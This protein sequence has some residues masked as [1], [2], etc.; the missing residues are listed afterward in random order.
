MRTTPSGKRVVEGGVEQRAR[1]RPGA[2][3]TLSPAATR[4]LRASGAFGQ[5]ARRLRVARRLQRRR[6]AHDRVAEVDR[7]VGD[8][9]ERRRRRPAPACGATRRPRSDS[10]AATSAGSASSR[11]CFRRFVIEARHAEQ[12]AE[13]AQHLPAGTRVAERPHRAVEALRAA[14]A[15]DEGAGGFGER[16]DRQHARRRT[17]CAPLR[18]GENA[19]TV[20]ACASAVDGWLR[21]RAC[22]TRARRSSSSIGLA[23]LLDH[24]PRVQAALPRQ[25]AGE[26]AADRVGRL[27]Q[28]AERRA[29]R[30]RD[31]LRPR[32]QLGRLRMLHG[33]VAE[34]DRLALA[35]QQA[36]ARS[37]S[38]ARRRRRRSTG[39]GCA[40]LLARSPT[41]ISAS[42]C[43][44]RT[45]ARSACSRPASA[46]RR[47]RACSTR[48][49][50]SRAS[51]RGAGGPT[52][53]AGPCAGTNRRAAR[54]R[55]C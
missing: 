42:A 12:V 29:G 32:V 19:M 20:S 17:P 14:F 40:P 21:I 31:P 13:H 26:I 37:S 44:Q 52:A 41:A 30:L 1:R 38:P 35:R 48:Q 39:A 6:A 8:A 25:R 47:R 4:R 55:A 9:L 36:R 22:R 23:R 50:R 24:L 11:T 28:H 43:T 54:G 51:S 27:G 34:Q 5:R 46:G 49:L 18:Y 33:R 45:D 15:V 3:R 16:R 53:A 2:P 7:H 10:R